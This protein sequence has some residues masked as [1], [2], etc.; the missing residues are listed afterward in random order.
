MIR[1]YLYSIPVI[2][3]VLCFI[4]CAQVAPLTGGA[5]DTTPPVLTEAIP[6]SN[7]LN[8]NNNEIIL[9][10]NE[11][12]KLK[13]LKNQLL[14][15][16]ALKTDPEITAD[17]KKIK[18]TLK[19]EE[20]LPNTT[21]RF[22]FG[23]AI[24]DMTEG[25]PAPNF[26]YIFSTGSFIDSLKLN[27]TI[28]DAFNEQALSDVVVGLYALN[29]NNGDSLIYKKN[30]DYITRS[31]GGGEYHFTHLPRQTFKVISFTDKNKNY[32]Y[33]PETEKIG[34]REE[35]LKLETDTVI[36]MKVFQEDPA[37]TYIKKTT[38]PYYGLLNIVYNRK[39]VFACRLLYKQPGSTVTELDKGREKD[40]VAFIYDGIKDSLSVIIAD[41]ISKKSDTVK[42]TIPKLNNQRKKSFLV[43]TNLTNGILPFDHSLSLGFLNTP[44]TLRSD[45]R[46]L[47]VYR[48]DSLWKEIP[49]DILYARP[50]GAM[51]TASLTEGHD[52]KLKIDTAAFYD[53][54]GRYNDSMIVNFKRES[55][56]ELGK[57]TIK[58]LLNKK[59][60]YIIQLINDKGQFVK[61]HFISL[62]LSSSNAVSID[63]TGIAPGVYT[64]KVIFD[65]NENKKWD[66]GNYLL[67]K[68]PEKVFISSKQVKVLP[69]WEVE[70][71]ILIK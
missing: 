52:Y 21:Y 9:R 45:K 6:Q 66:T 37:R 14:V 7:T 44:D 39:S 70:E 33:D 63:F 4:R 2:L 53:F 13:D 69:D 28:T 29:D 47:H 59:Q 35:D 42:I 62:S 36:N 64:V 16:P 43:K 55:V 48:K 50:L 34:F 46:K 26:E 20:L 54:N 58:L 10:F 65:D 25:N 60:A 56:N 1:H 19:K 5:R 22:Y 11:Y 15:S 3:L 57:A 51:V 40:T 67:R 68:Q 38:S 30:P 23:N 8:F 61:Q 71:E 12:V 49:A 17:G 18:V 27:G 31:V 32:R 24:V 41:L